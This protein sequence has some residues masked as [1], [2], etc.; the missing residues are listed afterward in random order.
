M[1]E[2]MQDKDEDED[3]S[4]SH[5]EYETHPEFEPESSE[6]DSQRPAAQRRCEPRASGEV[7]RPSR[8]ISRMNVKN[9]SESG[10]ESTSV[11]SEDDS[12]TQPPQRMDTPQAEEAV[13]EAENF[14]TSAHEP[15]TKTEP[16]KP[17]PGAG[18]KRMYDRDENGK[19]ICFNPDGSRIAPKQ[20]YTYINRIPRAKKQRRDRAHRIDDSSED[21]PLMNRAHQIEMAIRSKPVEESRT[22]DEVQEATGPDWSTLTF[23]T[24]TPSLSSEEEAA[25]WSQEAL[26]EV[27]PETQQASEGETFMPPLLPATPDSKIPEGAH[28]LQAPDSEPTAFSDDSLS[29]SRKAKALYYKSL[30]REALGDW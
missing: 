13:A 15:E 9:D 27:K 3:S 30:Y 4:E 16:S 18:R 12:A 26:E 6:D 14:P 29:A 22:V 20:K 2:D 25:E 5:S 17:K 28:A 23:L 19:P 8:A 1:A 11:S 7:V 24:A 10:S 21:G